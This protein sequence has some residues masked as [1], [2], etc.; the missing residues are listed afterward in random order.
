MDSWSALSAD[1]SQEVKTKRN[2]GVLYSKRTLENFKQG[3]SWFLVFLFLFCK[4]NLVVCGKLIS[5]VLE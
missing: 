2:A 5:G 1:E 3:T 4:L